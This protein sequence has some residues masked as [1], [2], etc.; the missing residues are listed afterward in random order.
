MGSENRVR[1]KRRYGGMDRER[2]HVCVQSGEVLTPGMCWGCESNHRT[3]PCIRQ[4][5]DRNESAAREMLRALVEACR[6]EAPK[7]PWTA[8][9]E[10]RLASS[11]LFLKAGGA[12][13]GELHVG[14]DYGY[15]GGD[16]S[17][18]VRM[19]RCGGCGTFNVVGVE[20]LETEDEDHGCH[21]CRFARIECDNPACDNVNGW[22]PEEGDGEIG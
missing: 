12:V 16:A 17:V 18:A 15:P 20:V 8:A 22:E 6:N 4:L 14:V 10:L 19:V 5:Q 3:E 11:E 9:L 1:I 7:E 21:D 2:R 13:E